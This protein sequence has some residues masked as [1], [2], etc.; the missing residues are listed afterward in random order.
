MVV[1]SKL[2]ILL[3]AVVLAFANTPADLVRAQSQ[4]SFVCPMHA[5]VVSS[6]PGTCPHCGMNLTARAA[7]PGV[8]PKLRRKRIAG[9]TRQAASAKQR[10]ATTTPQTAPPTPFSKLSTAE[11]VREME[12]LSPTYEYSCVMHAEVRLAQPGTCPKCG[13]ALMSNSPSV[14]GEYKLALSTRPLRPKP[15]EKARLRFVISNPETGAPVKDFV[16]NHE[17]LFHLFIVSNDMTEYQHIHPQ[18]ERDGS[19]V[20]ETVLPHTGLYKLHADFFPAGGTPQI[21]H[22]ELSTAGYRT[23]RSASPAL[24]TPDK[25]LAKTVDGMKINLELGGASAPAAGALIPLKYR[26]TDE[27]TGEPVRNLEP[28]LGAWGHTLILNADQ[29]EYLHSHPTE[30]VPDN[31]DLATLR[32]GP[33]VEFKTMFPAAGNYR[34]WTQFQRAG[35]VTTVFFTIRVVD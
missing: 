34:I 23:S 29:S 26:L 31:V 24:L 33:E 9:G 21:L 20:I 18:L 35:R 8:K 14:R 19:F 7:K 27:R 11:R 4:N 25:T 3:I 32:G 28:Y 5:G 1:T 2:S 15:G 22:R 6:A 17:K 13:M 16:L 30:M 12:R 10:S